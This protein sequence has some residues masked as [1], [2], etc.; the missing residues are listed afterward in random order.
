[1]VNLI[2]CYLAVA[3]LVIILTVAHPS[4]RRIFHDYFEAGHRFSGWI[5]LIIFWVYMGLAAQSAAKEEGI[6]VGIYFVRSPNFWFFIISTSCILLSW[7]RLRLCDVYPEF[8]S[9]HVIRLHFTHRTIQPS[10][11]HRF[12]TNPLIEWHSFAMIPD[13]DENGNV[14]GFSILVSNAG[15][16]TK[17]VIMNPPK[18]L[19]TRGCPTHEL[20]YTSHLF[21]RIVVVATGS[22]I[23]PCLSMFQSKDETHRRVLWSTP[24]PEKTYGP[25]IMTAVLK[26]D[27]DAVV[28]DT[29]V[30]G[31]PD[32]VALTYKLVV[33]SKAEAVF[34]VSNAKLSREVV[35]A[36]ETRGIPAYAPIFDS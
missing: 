28:W 35:Y 8:L 13:E 24:Y 7:F 20:L 29:R 14:D 18:K 32:M 21:K 36:M 34:I 12:S 33:Q 4:F 16:W 17:S 31:R 10:Y 1:L 6:P 5:S 23:G 9:E 22:G 27:P 2:L 11:V 19:W 26:T 15:D 25:K 3:M 30:S